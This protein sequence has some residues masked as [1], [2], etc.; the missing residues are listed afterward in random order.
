MRLPP[1]ITMPLPTQG[2]I[3][4]LWMV[5]AVEL[6][7]VRHG[8]L[9]EVMCRFSRVVPLCPLITKGPELVCAATGRRHTLRRALKLFAFKFIS[10]VKN[11]KR[12][13]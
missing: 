3:S 11:Y 4:E 1:E 12:S 5:M 7:I 6:V 10:F 2:P 8:P 13:T 9:V